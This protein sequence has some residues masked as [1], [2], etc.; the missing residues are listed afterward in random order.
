MIFISSASVVRWASV[1][2][3]RYTLTEEPETVLPMLR[4]AAIASVR[5]ETPALIYAD[6]GDRTRCV[7]VYQVR[8]A[9]EG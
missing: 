2:L 9:Q 6:S 4:A 8:E 5:G 1:S 3:R 7:W